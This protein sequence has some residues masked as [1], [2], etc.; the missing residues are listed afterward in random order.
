MRDDN[1]T[2]ILGFK[3]RNREEGAVRGRSENSDKGVYD[4]K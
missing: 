4:W 2:G 3:K 1:D